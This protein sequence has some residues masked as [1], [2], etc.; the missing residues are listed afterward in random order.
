MRNPT[1]C[2]LMQIRSM[3]QTAALFL[4]ST[5]S[6]HLSPVLWAAPSLRGHVHNDRAGRGNRL[7]RIISFQEVH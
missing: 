6:V 4:G 7:V 2:G 3:P 1:G 5:P